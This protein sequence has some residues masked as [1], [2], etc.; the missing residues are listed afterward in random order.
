MIRTGTL[1]SGLAL[2]AGCAAPSAAPMTALPQGYTDDLARQELV[3][4]QILQSCIW[5]G[6]F[7]SQGSPTVTA[8]PNRPLPHVAQGTAQ[9]CA[10]PAAYARTPHIANWVWRTLRHP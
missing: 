4:R 9:V 7:Q 5:S 2:L 3:E 1:C 6:Y 8:I 10:N